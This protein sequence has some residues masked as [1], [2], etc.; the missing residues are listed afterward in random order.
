MEQEVECS[1]KGMGGK[2]KI[3]GERASP[4]SGN[5]ALQYGWHTYS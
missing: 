1:F 2:S 3:G 5:D 4:S